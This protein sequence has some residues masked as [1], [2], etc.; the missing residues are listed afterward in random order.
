M[1]EGAP[2]IDHPKIRHVGDQLEPRAREL[3]RVHVTGVVA[4]QQVVRIVQLE[5]MKADDAAV[6]L[7]N[8]EIIERAK[9]VDLILRGA[10]QL[11]QLLA[12]TAQ[13]FL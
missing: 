8:L 11:V 10:L 5:V 13:V 6:K 2:P 12:N 9:F 1:S 7:N 3:I 4:D